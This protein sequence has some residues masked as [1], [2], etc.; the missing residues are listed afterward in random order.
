MSSSGVNYAAFAGAL[1]AMLADPY[2]QTPAEQ[3]GSGPEGTPLSAAEQVAE[4]DRLEAQAKAYRLAAAK[5]A[6]DQYKGGSLAPVFSGEASQ[7]L[8][9]LHMEELAFVYGD[10]VAHH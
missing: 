10:L 5:A 3:Q 6:F 2:P 7:K 4:F 1:R 8:L 9:R